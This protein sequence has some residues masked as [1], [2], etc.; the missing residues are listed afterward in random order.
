M[1]PHGPDAD[2]FI[3]AS[4]ADLKPEKFD[5]GLAFMFESTMFLRLTP[6]ALEAPFRDVDYQECWQRLPRVFNPNTPVVKGP[7]V[8]ADKP[9]G[10]TEGGSGSAKGAVVLSNDGSSIQ[11]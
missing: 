1:T 8:V 7:L 2:T 9:A 11:L 6:L 5:A 3:K 10:A 4:E